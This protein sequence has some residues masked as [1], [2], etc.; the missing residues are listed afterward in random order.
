MPPLPTPPSRPGVGFRLRSRQL[1]PASSQPKMGT[2]PVGQILPQ[3]FACKRD[4]D[5]LV[6]ELEAV[7]A[8]E[9]APRAAHLHGGEAGSGR[10]LLL[11][12]HLSPGRNAWLAPG[13]PTSW[14]G[15]LYFCFVLF[16]VFQ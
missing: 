10:C 14:P 2:S 16:F 5:G 15:F 4:R 8:E 11:R 12:A 6:R 7:G 13:R 3:N 1:L 9:A